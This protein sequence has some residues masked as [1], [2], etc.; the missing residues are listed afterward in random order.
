MFK[1][2]ILDIET[3]GTDIN[4]YLTDELPYDFKNATMRH[5]GFFFVN[6]GGWTYPKTGGSSFRINNVLPHATDSNKLYL[7]NRSGRIQPGD[8]ITYTY[9]DDTVSPAT[10]TTFNGVITAVGAI[11]GNGF[12]MV[13]HTGTGI[14]HNTYS[15]KRNWMSIDD[16]FVS[17]RT[18]N[19]VSNGPVADKFIFRIL[20]F[21]AT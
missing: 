4:L 12:S 20:L 6:F 17:H 18:G 13:T 14:L 3:S 15:A 7:P 9:E 21:V 16:V 11:D 2:R 1:S 8:T 10:R 19:F 5:Y